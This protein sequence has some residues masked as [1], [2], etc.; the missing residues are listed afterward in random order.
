MPISL[1]III[2]VFSACFGFLIF[3]IMR[4]NKKIEYDTTEVE[5]ATAKMAEIELESRK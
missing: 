5:V 4:I 3:A 2:S 1:A